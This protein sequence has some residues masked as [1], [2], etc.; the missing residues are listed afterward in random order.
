MLFNMQISTNSAA[1]QFWNKKAKSYA[2]SPIADMDA[3]RHTLERT[4]EHLKAGDQILELGCGTGSTAL[5]LAP[6]VQ[7]ITASDIS[8]K[9]VAIGREK[10]KAEGIENIRFVAADLQDPVLAEQPYDAILAFN[11]LHLIDD[12]PSA[13]AQIRARL[14]PGGLF[15]SKTFCQPERF[16]LQVFT[17]R[18]LL[19]LLQ[20]LKQAPFVQFMT[21]DEMDQHVQRAG[22]ELLERSNHPVHPPRRYI[23]ARK[24]TTP[25]Q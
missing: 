6:S 1:A 3:Y 12:L 14:K 20:W 13:L 24:A 16:S 10:A 17:M 15:I 23:V 8:D 21:V 22:F 2:K 11:L 4:R 25:A 9:M 7:S 18:A 19:P 5:L